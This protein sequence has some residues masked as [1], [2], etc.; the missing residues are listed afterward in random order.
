VDKRPSS[1]FWFPRPYRAERVY[2]GPPRLKA[3]LSFLGPS[4]R[5]V[6]APGVPGA[7]GVPG[8]TGAIGVPGAT[9]VTGVDGTLP[10]AIVA[11]P[12]YGSRKV[13]LGSHG[14]DC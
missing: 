1:S 8:A 11:V 4:G 5:V 12:L 6:D 13:R 2:F 7:I 14:K 3:G 9:G 10:H